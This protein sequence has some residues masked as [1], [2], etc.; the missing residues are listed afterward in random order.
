MTCT[1]CLKFLGRGE[2]PGKELPPYFSLPPHHRSPR[3][4]LSWNHL[5]SLTDLPI[6]LRQ[7]HLQHQIR[8]LHS[9]TVTTRQRLPSSTTRPSPLPYLLLHRFC[10]C[11]HEFSLPSSPQTPSGPPISSQYLPLLSLLPLTRL[12]LSSLF[13][14]WIPSSRPSM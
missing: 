13:R 11:P 5:R 12:R 3:V 8:P 2:V 6:P 7:G 4:D 9:P 10:P 14:L 1:V